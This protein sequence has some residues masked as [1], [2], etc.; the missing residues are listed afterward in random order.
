MLRGRTRQRKFRTASL[1]PPDTLNYR[2]A[3]RE[4]LR[5][6]HVSVRFVAPSLQ[7]TEEHGSVRFARRAIY[8]AVDRVAKQ[9]CEPGRLLANCALKGTGVVEMASLCGPGQFV[10]RPFAELSVGRWRLIC[11]RMRLN[12]NT[13]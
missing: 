8:V 1:R 6:Q 10:T 7:Q 11:L 12:C 2:L 9:R 3:D 5:V 13:K 4:F